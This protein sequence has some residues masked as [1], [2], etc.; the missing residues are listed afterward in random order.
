MLLFFPFLSS[1][2]EGEEYYF[3]NHI[4]E[5]KWFSDSV[6]LFHLDSVRFNPQIEYSFSLELATTGLYPYREI[7]LEITHN[8][9]DTIMQT[10]T[11]K[12]ELT[13]DYGRWLGG[14]SGGINQSSLQIINNVHLDSARVYNLSINHL[15]S[16][17]PLN[18]V[19]KVGIKIIQSDIKTQ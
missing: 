12:H 18:G 1:C 9:T 15:M 10:D 14:G 17:N 11:L 2:T 3:Y 5:S 19:E 8:L 13:D 7:W 4:K 6:L 16:D